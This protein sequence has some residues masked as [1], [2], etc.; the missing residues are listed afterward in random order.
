VTDT[1]ALEARMGQREFIV[2]ISM[3][4]ALTALAIDLMLPAFGDMRA[5]FGLAADSNAVALAVTVFFVGIGLGQLAWGPLADALGRK[6]VLWIGLVVYVVGALGG[7]VAP[8]LEVLLGWRFVLGL[9][10]AAIRVVTMGTVRD[11]Y[12]GERMAKT[13]S[14]IT[15]VFILVPLLAPALGSAVLALGSWRWVFACV[16]LA[17]IALAAWSVRLP[18]TL[19]SAR[20]IPLDASRIAEAAKVV[21]TSRYA[22]GF[23]LAQT[24]AFG[25]FISYLASTQLIVDDVFGLGAWFPVIFGGSALV[26]G[27]ATLLNARLIDRV[28]LRRMLRVALGGYVLAAAAFAVV[29]LATAGK[30]PFWLYMATIVPLLL[31]HGLTLPNLNSAAMLP[32][33]RVAGTAAAIFGALSMLIG[34]LIGALIDA[35]YDGTVRPLAL[36]TL[37]VVAIAFGLARWSDAVWERD[38]ERQVLSPDEQAQAAIGAPVDLG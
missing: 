16:A 33:G 10:A 27:A 22:M 34:A 20:R 18:E 30:P 1:D 12:H 35:L 3:L 7:A 5:D 9:G 23:T 15:A 32:M 29:A 19:P 14:Y 26:L 2:L 31:M 25:F 17:A 21:L 13:L 28:G 4:S 11:R 24:A 38:A 6:R 36:A 37:V 8:S